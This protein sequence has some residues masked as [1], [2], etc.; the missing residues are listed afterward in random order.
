MMFRQSEKLTLEGCHYTMAGL[1]EYASQMAADENSP[2]WKRAIFR[3]ILEWL[4]SPDE[5]VQYSSGTS[6]KSKKL[7]ISR[8]AM[9]ESSLATGRF[10]NLMQG[11]TAL[12]CL[13]V[14]YIAGKMMIVRA[15]TCGLNLLIREPTGLPDMH[16]TAG[17]DICAMVPLQVINLLNACQPFTP[18]KYLLIGGAEISTELA[19]RVRDLSSV[20]VYAT[21]GMA[22][23][24]S[25]IALRKLTGPCCEHDYHTLPGITLKK[26]E[27]DCLVISAPYLPVPVITND[28]VE[29]TGP[30]SFKWIGRYDN[31]IN[32]GGIKIVPEEVEMLIAE[33]TGL[34]C[35][36]IG[37]PDTKFGHQLVLVAEKTQESVNEMDIKS[38]LQRLLPPKIQPKEIIWIEKF[39][40][41][42]AFKLD[43][44]KITE[45]VYTML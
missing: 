4:S 45:L 33:K 28:L 7:R 14:E 22:E 34:V 5:I 41:N 35:A 19:N 38:A 42:P 2:P 31:L 12:L 44:L 24:C 40:R 10:F 20:Q 11:Q 29:F 3:F 37:L 26:D 43:R 18:L 16:E 36:L 32:S 21:Y 39:P 30:G 15:F 25:H 8:Q 23:T 6:G 27:R 9:I 17:I 1:Q 13:P